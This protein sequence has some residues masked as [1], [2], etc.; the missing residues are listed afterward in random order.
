M[1]KEATAHQPTPKGTGTAITPLVI[2]DLEA[3]S[4]AGAIKYGEPLRANNGRDALVDAYQE[5]LD[6]AQYIRQELEERKRTCTWAQAEADSD[7]WETTCKNA[8]CLTDGTPKENKIAFCNFCG[9]P[10][11]EV[12]HPGYGIEDEEAGAVAGGAEA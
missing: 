5:A 11:E 2:A 9:K 3:R 8:W 6:L 4:A 12:K 7:C 10:V 1:T